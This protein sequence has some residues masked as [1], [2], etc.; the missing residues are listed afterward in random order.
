MAYLS[1]K[2]DKFKTEYIKYMSQKVPNG[3]F[4]LWKVQWKKS[5]D[6]NKGCLPSQ[7]L[8]VRAP[9]GSPSWDLVPSPSGSL[10]CGLS[11]FSHFSDP[12]MAFLRVHMHVYKKHTYTVLVKDMNTTKPSNTRLGLKRET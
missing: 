4:Y 7:P 2:I 9:E 10:P 6:V 11:A 3:G 1:H 8:S 12:S 5:T